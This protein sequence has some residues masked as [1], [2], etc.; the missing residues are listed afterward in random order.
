MNKE[1]AEQKIE[2]LWKCPKCGAKGDDIQCTEGDWVYV[3][4]ALGLGYYTEIPKKIWCMRCG[5]EYRVSD[6]V[7]VEF[8]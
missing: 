4:G 3:R 1:E 6:K 5:R 8:T 2:K 7:K